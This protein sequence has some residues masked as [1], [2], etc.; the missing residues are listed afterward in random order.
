MSF[1]PTAVKPAVIASLICSLT[2][3]A[4]CT[5]EE[6]FVDYVETDIAKSKV[7]DLSR[8]IDF[9]KSEVRFEQAE[10]IDGVTNGLNR[11][12][13]YSED[14]KD[15]PWEPDATLEPLIEQYSELPVSQRFNELNFLNTDPYFTCSKATGFRSLAN[16]WQ[17]AN[18]ISRSSCIVWLRT[19]WTSPNSTSRSIRF[20]N[21]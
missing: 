13:S 17:T 1:F 4:G 2:F 18:A 16:A 12:V 21:N 14:L 19:I 6:S 15:T 3:A 11:W 7:D 8:S 10:F 5:R 9:V 20:S